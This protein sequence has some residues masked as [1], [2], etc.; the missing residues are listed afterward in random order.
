MVRKKNKI[1][2]DRIKKK[3]GKRDFIRTRNEERTRNF[4]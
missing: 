2:N 3:I 1:I 4:K